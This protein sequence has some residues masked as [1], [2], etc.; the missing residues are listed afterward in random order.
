MDL[1]LYKGLKYFGDGEDYTV[2]Y[3]DL[4]CKEFRMFMLGLLRYCEQILFKLDDIR[5]P[6]APSAFG[7]AMRRS[8]DSALKDILDG[9]GDDVRGPK[10]RRGSVRRS[11]S[12]RER[13]LIDLGREMG[14]ED[15]YQTDE[16]VVRPGEMKVNLESRSRM[17]SRSFRNWTARQA[18]GPPGPTPP[19]LW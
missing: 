17:I 3:L 5:G 19:L 18:Q 11:I 15:P 12:S 10:E 14:Y 2:T 9:R 7:N 6:S 4:G 13:M 16:P 8:A 1:K